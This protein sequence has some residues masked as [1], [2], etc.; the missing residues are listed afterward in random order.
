MD[1]HE[2]AI[3]VQDAARALGLSTTTERLPGMQVS[4]MPHQLIGVSWMI[5]QEHGRIAGGILA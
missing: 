3:P 4:L 5:K 1:D 2:A